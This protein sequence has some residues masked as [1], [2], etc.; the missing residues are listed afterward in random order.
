MLVNIHK[1]ISMNTSEIKKIKLTLGDIEILD[2]R[3][4][5]IVDA[6]EKLGEEV[7]AQATKILEDKILSLGSIGLNKEAKFAQQILENLEAKSKSPEI[8]ISIQNALKMYLSCISSWARGAG[9][10]KYIVEKG[11]GNLV[12]PQMLAIF[13][14]NDNTGCQT[15][16]FRREGGSIVIWHTEEDERAPLSERF[17]KLRLAIFHSDLNSSFVDIFSFIY[18]DLLPGAAFNWRSDGYFQSVDSIYLEQ[19]PYWF[20]TK[21]G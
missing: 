12:S 11:L 8:S 18:P 10:E 19:I 9:F 5:D 20:T 1:H 2:Y 7:S 3:R 17:D 6:H 13:L 15:G 4:L 14:Q 21:I 16:V